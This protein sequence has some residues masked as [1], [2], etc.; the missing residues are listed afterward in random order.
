LAGASPSMARI[1]EVLSAYDVG[2]LLE[3]PDLGGGTANRNVVLTTDRGKFFLRRR[4]PEY[5][6]RQRILYDHALMGHLAQK[7][8]PGPLPLR[9]RDGGTWVEIDG[10]IWELHCY[11]EGHEFNPES[12]AQLSDSGYALAEWH[13]AVEDF[14]CPYRKEFPRYDNPRDVKAQSEFFRTKAKGEAQQKVLDYVWSQADL[15][16]RLL[17]DRRYGALPRPVIHGD[18]HP[19]NL[20]FRGNKV[21]GI[22]D[23][24][25]ASRELR[26]RD[27]ADGILYVAGKREKRIDGGDIFSLTQSCQIDIP[28]STKFLGAYCKSQMITLEELEA[29]PLVM[30][31]RWM[32]SR[33][34]GLRKVAPERKLE[35]FLMGIETPLQWLDKN[36]EKMVKALIRA[37]GL[38][39]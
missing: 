12:E 23:L 34:S 11:I 10:E 22:F 13:R 18:Y 29:L 6:D 16:E 26:V 3:M 5:C 24:D 33:V 30:R 2:D 28:R 36:E 19:A 25:W 38:K 37:S 20:K 4:R 27:L 39:T 1:R 21:V 17:D 31:A 8:I 32:Y 9:A 7:G 14:T 35:F 15:V